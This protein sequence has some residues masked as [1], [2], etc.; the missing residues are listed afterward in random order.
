M[1]R[2]ID[3]G[4]GG[5]TRN[6]SNR[7]VALVSGGLDSVVSLAIADRELDVRLVLFCNYGQRALSSERASAIDVVSYYGL[8]FREVDVTWMRDLSPEGMRDFEAGEP[9]RDVD[10]DLDSLDAVWIPNRNGLFLNVAAAF[11]ESY[12]CGTVV[13]GFNREEA[14]EFPD[15]TREYVDAVNVGFEYSTRFGVR[16]VS[17]TLDLTKREILRKGIE[18]SAPLSAIWSCYRGGER[19][20]GSCASC[21]RLKVA[22]DSLE[23]EYRPIIEFAE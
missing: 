19:M 10:D 6:R 15:N 11:A 21:R 23:S 2:S 3:S 5:T 12:D 17:Y 9:A 18:L 22:I 14:V 7:A 4:D 16:V 13:T 20:C 8:P 1:T